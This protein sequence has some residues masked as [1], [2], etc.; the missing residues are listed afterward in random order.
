MESL[1]GRTRKEI[2]FCGISID[3]NFPVMTN[4]IK[5]ESFVDFSYQKQKRQA[6][7]LYMKSTLMY[8]NFEDCTS[9]YFTKKYY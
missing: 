5:T 7:S 2:S 3:E 9:S 4:H 6:V 8:V 1:L